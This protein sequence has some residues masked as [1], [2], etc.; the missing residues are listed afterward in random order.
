MKT[1]KFYQRNNPILNLLWRIQFKIVK[2]S[3]EESYNGRCIRCTGRDQCIYRYCPC[4]WKENLQ[5]I[6]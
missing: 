5:F 2:I 3:D 6:K 1:T 4:N